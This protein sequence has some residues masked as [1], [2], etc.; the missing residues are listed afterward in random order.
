[1][2]NY[3][4]NQ[5]SETFLAPGTNFVEDNFNMNQGWGDGFGII[6]ACYIYCGHYL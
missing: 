1:M 6:E 2:D 3:D 4:I 5:K